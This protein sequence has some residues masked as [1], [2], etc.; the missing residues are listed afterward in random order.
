MFCSYDTEIKSQVDADS[1]FTY[2]L[3]RCY[4]RHVRRDH[5]YRYVNLGFGFDDCCG[6]DRPPCLVRHVYDHGPLKRTA[7][8]PRIREHRSRGQ[9]RRKI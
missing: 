7:K 1:S 4:I 5:L 6:L 2:G 3:E 8:A 9:V